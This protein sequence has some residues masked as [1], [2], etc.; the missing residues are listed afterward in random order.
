M[1]PLLLAVLLAI[2]GPVVWPLDHG[3]LIRLFE[4]PAHTWGA[5]H[6]GIDIRGTAG[7]AVRSVGDGT[8]AFRG[9][10]GGKAVVVVSHGDVRSTYEP[11]LGSRPLGS[12]VRAGDVI[13]HL[14]AGHCFPPDVCLHL[15]LRR[16]DHYL[17]PRQLFQRVVLKSPARG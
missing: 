5:G 3:A 17:D 11:V 14:Q 15:G 12:Q 1:P 13:G 8:V 2:P 6:R 9:Q 4:P 7:Q 16:G 10:V